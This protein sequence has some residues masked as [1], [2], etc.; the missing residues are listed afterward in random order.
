MKDVKNPEKAKKKIIKKPKEVRLKKAK[1]RLDN[2]HRPIRWY[3]AF[4]FA[5]LP[6]YSLM[7][8]YTF[9]RNMI[10]VFNLFSDNARERFTESDITV[11]L[12]Y[13][14]SANMLFVLLI[15]MSVVLFFKLAELDT[16]C[17]KLL[18]AFLWYIGVAMSAVDIVG[19]VISLAISDFEQIGI[20]ILIIV[21]LVV[22]PYLI[23][24]YANL[25]Y[26]KKRD[27]LFKD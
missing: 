14:L 17:R 5:V 16:A 13:Y 4:R 25:K 12:I 11:M 24:I 19:P 20:A 27:Y 26:F 7:I 21:P 9:I 2:S 10:S 22:C 15:V 1:R 3:K 6:L 8:L 23:F 18:K